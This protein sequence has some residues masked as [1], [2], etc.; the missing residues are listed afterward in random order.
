[1]F[2]KDPN[3]PCAQTGSNMQSYSH[4]KAPRLYS[5][6]LIEFQNFIILFQC[7]PTFILNH[8]QSVRSS[9][10]YNL[11]KFMRVK[12]IFGGVNILLRG[13][14]TDIWWGSIPPAPSQKILL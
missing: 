13:V 5:G 8:Q 10:L 3:V 4:D 1:M 9:E 6:D 14:I 7:F 11:P 12:K 2:V